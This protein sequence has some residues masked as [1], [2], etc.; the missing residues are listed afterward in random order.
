MLLRG[1]RMRHCI[2]LLFL[3]LSICSELRAQP[4]IDSLAQ[5]GVCTPHG[6]TIPSILGL[7]RSKGLEVFQERIPNYDLNSQFT[8]TDSTFN[9]AIR[10]TKS[11]SARLRIPVVNKDYFKFIVGFKYYQQEF[12]FEQPVLEGNPFHSSI[13]DKPLRSM[14]L[15][16]YSVHSFIGNKYLAFRGT[17][18]LNGDFETGTIRSHQK[19][20]F[21]GL[22]GIKQH[23]YKTWGFGV[24]YSNSFGRSSVYPVFF[25]KHRYRPKWAVELLLPLSAR[26]LYRPNEKNNLYVETKLEGDNYN[27]N[28]D[29]FSEVPLYL[30][31]ADV[32]AMFT[33]E[34]EVYDFF[35]VSASGGYRW[36]INFD[37]SDSDAFFDRAF[38]LGN[39]DNLAISNTIGGAPF[40]RFGIFLVPP[41]KWLEE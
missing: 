39:S 32:K 41:K 9:N 3:S 21:T 23:R 26:L 22:Y 4:D 36:N 14:G 12:A 8:E 38:N 31:K 15:S 33:Y 40:F 30:E 16:L 25:L 19:T 5:L 27:I 24:S 34:H 13:E 1:V 20:S 29:G 37:V 2:L 11:W 6:F 10:R 28:L 7:P 35:W 18:R 17:L